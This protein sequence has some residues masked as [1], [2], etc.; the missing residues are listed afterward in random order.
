MRNKKLS[1]VLILTVVLSLGLVFSG[2]VTA[3]GEDDKVTF[4][5]SFGGDELDV[6][7]DLMDQFTED[8][9]IEVEVQAVSRNMRTALGSRVEAGNPPDMA[10]LPNPG[11]MKNFARKDQ[12]APIEWFKETDL[13]DK[14]AGGFL[15]SGTYNDTLYGVVP[16]ASLKSLVW[17]NKKVFEE[18]GYEV[19]ETLG[20]LLQLQNQ[21]VEDGYTPWAFGLESGD[22]TGWPGTDWIEDIMLRSAGPEVY[23]KW[24]NHDIAWTNPQVAQ[25]F[26]IFD[27]FIND[28]MVMGGREGASTIDFGDSVQY[29]LPTQEMDEP[30]ALMH[31]QATFIQDFLEDAHPDAEVGEDYDTFIFPSFGKESPPILVGG[32]IFIAFRDKPEVRELIK[33]FASADIQQTW[34]EE[35]PGRLAVNVDVPLSAYPNDTLRN[36][37]QALKEAETARFDG[38]DSMPAAVGSGEFFTA[39][40][41]FVQGKTSLNEVLESLETSADDAYDTGEATD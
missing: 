31:R 5:T 40:N 11:L 38:S 29:I 2:A 18:E 3:F 32:D 15:A 26:R 9:G 21:M 25:A 20:E 17:Y 23:D 7:K 16:G 8:T 6:F 19:P 4:V 34:V 1:T 36:A 30:R 22:A 39:M 24:V 27:L 35:N 14:Q 33:Y 37:A 41:N 28:E 10:N 12:I 13:A